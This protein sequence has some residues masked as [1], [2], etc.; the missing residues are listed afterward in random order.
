MCSDSCVHVRGSR[1]SGWARP[2][3]IKRRGGG[4]VHSQCWARLSLLTGT[5]GRKNTLILGQ[6]L[7]V[8][9]CCLELCPLGLLLLFGV[10]EGPAAVC[11][12]R[13]GLSSASFPE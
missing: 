4:Q 6:C 9:A 10:V 8:V 11:R 3:S 13:L 5:F 2:G 1:R 7:K 12:T